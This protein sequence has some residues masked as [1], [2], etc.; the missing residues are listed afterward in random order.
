MFVIFNPELREK[1]IENE[2][3]PNNSVDNGSHYQ[4]VSNEQTANKNSSE[5]P[6]H[7][8]QQ[9]VNTNTEAITRQNTINNSRH[10]ASN[11]HSADQSQ[12][13]SKEHPP[14]HGSARIETAMLLNEDEEVLRTTYQIVFQRRFILSCAIGTIVTPVF[15][16]IM[17]KFNTDSSSATLAHTIMVMVMS[18]VTVDMDNNDYSFAASSLV[19]SHIGNF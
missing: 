1:S 2:S 3:N 13:L 15:L 7:Q 16:V 17:Q 6:I 8:D 19:S 10:S 9:Q 12:N 4:A 5:N 11:L 14:S 18:N